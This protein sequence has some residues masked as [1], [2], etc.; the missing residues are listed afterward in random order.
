MAR[1][2]LDVF[3]RVFDHFMRFF[4]KKP[5]DRAFFSPAGY[6]PRERGDG[7]MAAE[8][9]AET[10]NSWEM[11]DSATDSPRHLNYPKYLN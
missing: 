10:L 9:P 1:V 8:I 4:T 3:G 5:L 11:I 7:K 6:S 2:Q